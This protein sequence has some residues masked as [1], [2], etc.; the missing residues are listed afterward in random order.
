MFSEQGDG[1]GGPPIF[2][3]SVLP[4]DVKR[5]A[6]PPPALCSLT[7][8]P[9]GFSVELQPWRILFILIILI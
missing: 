4:P 9:C 3:P 8:P 5:T 7:V 2:G 6:F 1:S